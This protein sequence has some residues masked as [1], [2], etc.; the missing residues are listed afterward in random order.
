MVQLP[1]PFL[2]ITLY[3]IVWTVLGAFAADIESAPQSLALDPSEAA[4]DSTSMPIPVST[5]LLCIKITN[6]IFSE[7]LKDSSSE[8]YKTLRDEVTQ[9]LDDVY[10]TEAHGYT[11]ISEMTFSKGSVVANTTLKFKTKEIAP[12]KIKN[13]FLSHVKKNQPANLHLNISFTEAHPS[14]GSTTRPA[15]SVTHTTASMNSPPPGD[16]TASPV[17]PGSTA[18]P[19]SSPAGPSSAGTSTPSNT[20]AA[21]DGNNEALVYWCC[22]RRQYGFVNMSEE[23]GIYENHGADIPMYT[24]HSHFESPNG[25]PY[26]DTEKP[27][28][29][30]AMYVVNKE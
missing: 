25:K 10:S 20:V 11:G 29:N 13:L 1:V 18:K 23:P 7:S 14:D 9:L 12:S 8:D 21:A 30:R 28:K 4:D 2:G 27:M 22:K 26:E 6:R 19:P 5:F 3:F 15:S 17:A 24:T 16:T